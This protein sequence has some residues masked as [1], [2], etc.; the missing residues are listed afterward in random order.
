MLYRRAKLRNLTFR[1]EVSGFWE[2]APPFAGFTKYTYK[3]W[4][5]INAK[6]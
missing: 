6:R 1:K 2:N 3:E 4:K 5:A